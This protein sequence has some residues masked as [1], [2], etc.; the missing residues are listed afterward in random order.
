LRIDKFLWFAR[1]TKTRALAQR[2]AEAGHI[3]RDGQRIDRAHATVKPGET[4]TLVLGE[5]VRI[6]RVEQIP[7]RRGPPIEAR[8]CYTD[9]PVDGA[10]TQT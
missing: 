1:V 7:A 6:L 10:G 4:L 8:A 3:R 5:R 9:I 2:L